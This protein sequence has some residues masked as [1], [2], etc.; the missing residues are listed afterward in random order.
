MATLRGIAVTTGTNDT[1]DQILRLARSYLRSQ[2][3]T[4]NVDQLEKV[5]LDDVF[6]LLER[7]SQQVDRMELR[8]LYDLLTELAVVREN[9]LLVQKASHEARL[10]KAIQHTG[11]LGKFLSLVLNEA[12]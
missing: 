10:I 8:R 9:H 7:L 1:S 12:T 3:V 4:D 5:A 6:R 11:R 2:K